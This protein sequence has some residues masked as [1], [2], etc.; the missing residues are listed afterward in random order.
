MRHQAGLVSPFKKLSIHILSDSSRIYK[1]LGDFQ[2]TN[3]KFNPNNEDKQ[4]YHPVTRGIYAS[5][6]VYY[7]TGMELGEYFNQNV[8]KKH[9][10]K[11]Y[12]G[13]SED[14]FEKER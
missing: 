13:I 11:F 10:L 2:Q 9:D 1:T 7:V 5:G 4:M 8:A 14:E 6:L 12:L 3:W